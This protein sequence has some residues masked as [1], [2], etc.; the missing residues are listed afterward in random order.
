MGLFI[1]L[2]IE[3]IAFCSGLKTALLRKSDNRPDILLHLLQQY[4]ALMEQKQHV[5][6]DALSFDAPVKFT[7]ACWP[8]VP[9]EELSLVAHL[10]KL[11][12]TAHGLFE[13]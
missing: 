10:H 5:H 2:V 12:S 8:S 4:L 13:R 1:C 9:Q 6:C 11:F 3:V 7:K